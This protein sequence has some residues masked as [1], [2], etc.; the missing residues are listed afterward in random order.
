MVSTTPPIRYGRG[1]NLRSIIVE[2]F[3]SVVVVVVS[4]SAITTSQD[5]VEVLYALPEPQDDIHMFYADM[6]K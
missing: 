1:T 5:L 6:R 3:A 2:E 4:L